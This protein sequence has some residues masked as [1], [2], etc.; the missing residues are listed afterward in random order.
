MKT[1]ED[2]LRGSLE[3]KNKLFN[4]KLNIHFA[5]VKQSN[6]QPLNDKRNGIST[7][8]K[9]DRQNSALQNLKD[10][11]QITENALEKEINKKEG[12]NHINQF[13]PKAILDLVEDGTLNQWRKHPNTFFVNGVDK[14]RIVWDMKQNKLAHRYLSYITDKEQ[15]SKFAKLYNTLYKVTL[16]V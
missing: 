2:I 5:T 8:N 14:A 4:D 10:S 12:V 6:G 15:Y 1:R 7:L 3:K 9:W 11:I 16:S 13:I